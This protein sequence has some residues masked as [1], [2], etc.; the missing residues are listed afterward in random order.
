MSRALLAHSQEALHKQHLV[1]CL[2][3]MSVGWYQG[4]M[5]RALLAHPQEGLY[6]EALGILVACYVRW[7]VPGLEWNTVPHQ[8]W[9]QS[10]DNM[11]AIYQVPLVHHLLRMSK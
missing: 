2:R 8:L 3:V 7:L 6:K 9:Y 1:Y 4:Y 11:Q 5:F 10:T